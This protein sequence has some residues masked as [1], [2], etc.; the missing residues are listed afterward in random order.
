MNTNEISFKD[1]S[2]THICKPH[3]KNSYI[4]IG[5]DAK[6]ILKTS[7]VSRIYIENLLNE[8]EGWIR[9]QLLKI[10]NHLIISKDI[11]NQE[12]AK[13]YLRART[14]YFCEIMNLK[15]SELKFKKLKSRWG[16]CNSK[17]VLT[18]NIL[19]YNTPKESID[20]VVVH[21]LAHLVHMNHSKEFHNL[22]EKYI[23]DAKKSRAVLKSV[24]FASK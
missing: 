22:V 3:L 24:N 10:S 17:G 6:I 7:K 21:E 20:Y 16:S 13:E 18:L 2:I 12:E 9:K 1:L 23:P 4:S 15:Y 14:D 5:A 19:L 8:K 11:Q